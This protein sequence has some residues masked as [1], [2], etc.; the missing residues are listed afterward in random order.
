MATALLARSGKRDPASRE[1]PSPS[2]DAH[3]QARWRALD[4]VRALAVAGVILYHAGVSW[5]PG[6]L[7][8]VDVFFVL[9]GYLITSLLLREVRGGGR[10]DLRAFW[11]RRAR[12]LLPALLLVLIAV[13]LWAAVDRSLDVHSIRLD[14]VSALLYVANWR[15]AFS[16][17]GYFSS[18]AAPSPVL[19]LWSLGVEEQFYLLWPLLVAAVV[20]LVRLGPRIARSVS[21]RQPGDGLD[22]ALDAGSGRRGVFVLAVV[23]ALASTGW[24]VYGALRG[25]DSSRLYY[26]TDTRALALLTGA[27]LATCLPLPRSP[28]A[29]RTN[30]HVVRRWSLVGALALGGLIAIFAMVSGQSQLLYHGGF[31]VV[32]VLVALVIATL[33]RAPR[34]P[35]SKLLGMPPLA[36]LGRISYGL[37]L[38]HWPVILYVNGARTHLSGTDLLWTRIGISVLLA[39]LSYWIMERPIL[40][41]WLPGRRLAATGLVGVILL[42]GVAGPWSILPRSSGANDVNFAHKLDSMAQQ[43]NQETQQLTRQRLTV[44]KPTPTPSPTPALSTTPGKLPGGKPYVPPNPVPAEPLNVL[45]VGD[46]TAWSAGLALEDRTT[47]WRVNLIN[48]SRIGCGIAPG[49]GAGDGDQAP[50]KYGECWNWPQQWQQTVAVQKPDVSLLIVG[51]WEVVNRN[52]NG[53]VM[54]VGQPVYDKLLKAQFE[55]A[56]QVLGSAGGKVALATAPCYQRPERADGTYWPQDDCR[57]VQ[58]FNKIVWAVAAEHPSN[59]VV[60]DLYQFFSP[61]G[62]W[63]LDIGGH[64]VRDPDGIHFNIYGGEWLAPV[65]LGGLRELMGLPPLPSNPVVAHVN[66][67]TGG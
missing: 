16:H 28:R 3:K 30:I 13:M 45:L 29:V 1:R 38:W 57:R 10:V 11:A 66:S 21:R 2:P 35:L 24:L 9:S 12:R 42:A 15:F 55:R 25:T 8:G 67:A 65:F 40:G 56:V 41:G 39:E 60:L 44:P 61:D 5:V 23:G 32:A 26:G 49:V 53:K 50:V 4:G 47:A 14:V 63:H 31:L 58:D 59:V 34:G 36:H 48:G 20:G 7:L 46:S 64:Q 27:V 33:I 62:R 22:A 51:H 18:S 17:Q 6:G 37:Y 54:H 43:Q 19:H 52:V